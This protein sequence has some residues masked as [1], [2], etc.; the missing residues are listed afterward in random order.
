M[1]R[2]LLRTG[3]SLVGC[4]LDDAALDRFERY[5]AELLHW[6]RSINL[7]AITDPQHVVIKHFIDSLSIVPLLDQGIRLLDIGSG[8]GLP[9]LAVAVVRPDLQVT[10]LDAVEKKVRFQ[11]HLCRLLGLSGVEVVHRR[12]EQLAQERPGCYDLVVSRAFRDLERFAQLAL[13]LVRPCGR[14]LAMTSGGDANQERT[15]ELCARHSLRLLQQLD[16]A[17]PESMG[18]RRLLLFAK[19]DR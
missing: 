7:T 13:P 4:C 9:G 1:Q 17:L 3:A 5:L 2:E 14:L 16:Y 8:A 15:A 6:N 10:S 11:R 19:T 18:Q 12:V